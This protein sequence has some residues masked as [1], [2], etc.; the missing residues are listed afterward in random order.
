MTVAD[1]S[2][3]T[4]TTGRCRGYRGEKRRGEG[5][6]GEPAKGRYTGEKTKE[7]ALSSVASGADQNHQCST[8]QPR[9]LSYF[10]QTSHN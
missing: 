9:G 8:E 1:A 3:A 7:R 10:S 5:G 6:A 4:S 2:C